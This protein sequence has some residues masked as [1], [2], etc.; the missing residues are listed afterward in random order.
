[1]QWEPVV[2]VLVQSGRW[3]FLSLGAGCESAFP[4]VLPLF[5]S[6]RLSPAMVGACLSVDIGPPGRGK[7]ML[8]LQIEVTSLT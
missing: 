8:D 4:G 7:M 2:V 6:H 1:M 5:L 3:G